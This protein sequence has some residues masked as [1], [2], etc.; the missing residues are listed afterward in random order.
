MAFI[1]QKRGN[2]SPSTNHPAEDSVELRFTRMLRNRTD[3][4]IEGQAASGEPSLSLYR[5]D[6]AHWQFVHPEKAR[7]VA[8]KWLEKN[9]PKDYDARKADACITTGTTDL[10][11]TGTAISTL[12]AKR[13]LR[14]VVPLQDK[15]LELVDG[16]WQVLDPDPELGMTYAVPAHIDTTKIT[17]GIYTPAATVPPSTKFGAF[18]TRF[19]PERE[20]QGRLAEIAAA[21]LIPSGLECSFLLLGE[22]A[23]GKST[24]LH[25][26]SAFHPTTTTAIRIEHLDRPFE[27]GTIPGKSL[28]IA[29]EVPSFIAAEPNQVFKSLVSRDEVKIEKKHRDGVTIKPRAT[30]YMAA[31]SPPRFADKTYGHERKIEVFAFN[32]RIEKQDRDP[33][34][35]KKITKDPS[36]L[37]VV[38]DWMLAGVARLVKREGFAEPTASQKALAEEIKLDNDS[39]YAFLQHELIVLPA[40]SVSRRWYSKKQDIYTE[41]HNQTLDSGQKP[42]AAPQFWKLLKSRIEADQQQLIEVRGSSRSDRARLVNLAKVSNQEAETWV[43]QAATPSRPL[44][45]D[46]DELESTDIPFGPPRHS[47]TKPPIKP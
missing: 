44:L 42:V 13:E 26:L 39:I 43:K 5:W 16:K 37:A 47:G 35:A 24:F 20:D 7:A 6:K 28:A 8:L 34:F 30:F 38:L 1:P 4:A 25:I 46:K 18:L 29:W 21:S 2:A 41:Y 31:N 19:I 10:M 32:Q 36:E 3:I 45:L 27:L 17:D 33:S 40:D 12:E 22:G 23:N 11:T 15:Y 14:I 9:S